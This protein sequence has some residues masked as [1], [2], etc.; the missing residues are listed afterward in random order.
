MGYYKD[1]CNIIISKY[2]LFTI[3]KE[4]QFREMIG[5]FLFFAEFQ[6]SQVKLYYKSFT[7]EFAFL[8]IS[9]NDLE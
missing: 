7:F 8:S 3:V 2:E 5:C 4:Q 6:N 1:K 9:F